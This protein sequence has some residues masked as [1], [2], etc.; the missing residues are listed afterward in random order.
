MSKFSE[1]NPQL[2]PDWMEWQKRQILM[3]AKQQELVQLLAE[4]GKDFDRYGVQQDPMELQQ[5][6]MRYWTAVMQNPEKAIQGQMELWQRYFTLCQNTTR[7][8]QGEKANPIVPTKP[9]RRFKDTRWTEDPIFSHLRQS[10]ELMSGWLQEQA[11][12]ID[13]IDHKTAQKMRF[14]MRNYTDALSPSN[15]WMTNPEVLDETIKTKGQNLLK[16]MEN[17]VADLKASKTLPKISMVKEG[18][19]EVGR[20]LATTKGEV[21]FENDTLQIIQY[22]PLTEQ[23]YKTPLVILSPWINKYYILDMQADNSFVR[24]AVEQ[25]HTVFITSWKNAESQDVDHD[26]FDRMQGGLVATIETAQRETGEKQVNVIGYC[27]GGTLLTTALA[28]WAARGEESPV[29]SAT[30]FTC[31][32]DFEDSGELALFTDESQISAMEKTMQSLGYLDAW[33]THTTFNMMRANDLIWSFVV[34]NYLMGREPFPFDLLYWNSDAT[35]IPAA[36]H[37]FYLR[38]M[39]MHNNLAKGKLVLNKTRLDVTKINTPSY[40]ISAIEDHIAPWQAT[41]N[42]ARLLGGD[43]T[44]T[45]SGSGHIAGIVNPPAKN[46][47]GYWTNDQLPKDCDKWLASAKQHEGSWW[48]HWAMWIAKFG[49]DK[50]PARDIKNPIEPAP[51]RYVKV[52]AL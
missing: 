3:L 12:A 24:W 14:A 6:V 13:S 5:S 47:Y 30:F 11:N 37:S 4:K 40:F 2:P 52:R 33:H 32:I 46:K 48:T 28:Y 26:W 7:R 38:Q 16:G 20:N 18:M 41:Y 15:F 34:N 10:H 17:L 50:I 49:G 29:K 39:Y 8:L 36:L 23:V 1:N 42:G 21:V 31:L 51:G 27:I 19:F 25:G 43:V 9:D 35:R 44:F 22:H 45:L